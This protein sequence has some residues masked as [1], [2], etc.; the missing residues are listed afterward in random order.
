MKISFIGTGTM[1]CQD[2][3]N[4]SILIDD[5]ILFDIGSGTVNQL[6][7]MGKSLEKIRYLFV[8][9]Y[10]IDH[11]LDIAFL[12]YRRYA[13]KK[14]EE[15][16]TIIGPAHIKEKVIELMNF[17]HGDGNPN[18]YDDIEQKFNIKFIELINRDIRIDD[19]EARAITMHHGT[20]ESCNGYIIKKDNKTVGYTG[21]TTI[22]DGLNNLIAESETIMIDGSRLE[23]T[24]QHLGHHRLIE[25]ANQNEDKTFFVIHRGDY[26]HHDQIANVIYP[27]DSEERKLG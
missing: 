2:R 20:C 24:D 10:H 4:T 12:L 7:N 21:D 26:V 15:C 1:G 14:M 19:M 9:H 18:K 8:S 17:T 3:I 6:R 22:C 13:Q 27:N 5:E 23:T 16:L 25:L 11:F